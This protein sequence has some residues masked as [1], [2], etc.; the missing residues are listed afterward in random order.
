M[1]CVQNRDSF[2]S[3]FFEALTHTNTAKAS[4]RKVWIILCNATERCYVYQY[5]SMNCL[6][7]KQCLMSFVCTY[8]YVRAIKK[9]YIRLFSVSLKEMVFQRFLL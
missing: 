2:V 7:I 9:Y 5:M 8:R 3:V 4:H 6:I 1:K